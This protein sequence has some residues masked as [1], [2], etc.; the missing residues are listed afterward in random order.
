MQ[1][2]DSVHD[3]L[4]AEPVS[5][6][7]ERSASSTKHLKID[8]RRST[9]GSNHSKRSGK[10]FQFLEN[11]FTHGEP[12]KRI[13]LY[14]IIHIIF[15]VLSQIM[16]GAVNIIVIEY[17]IKTKD[18]HAVLCGMAWHFWAV[19]AILVMAFTNAWFGISRIVVR[20]IRYLHMGL[21]IVGV[22]HL[23]TG[24][25]IIVIAKDKKVYEAHGIM[26]IVTSVMALVTVV[27]GP[28]SM[29]APYNQNIKFF[30]ITL[31]L[32]TFVLSTVVM[33]LGFHTKKFKKQAGKDI[34]IVITVFVLFYT[35][36]IITTVIINAVVKVKNSV[37]EEE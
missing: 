6:S 14:N 25:V 5:P 30:H 4:S 3:D 19:E 12:R 15:M 2:L 29:V 9:Q 16:V 35:I 11:R 23:V 17:T 21:Q 1:E 18:A 8:T 37:K 33:I 7:I 36:Y 27:A 10:H 24:F 20:R 26:G 31:A 28:T 32:P 34:A 13:R 22:I